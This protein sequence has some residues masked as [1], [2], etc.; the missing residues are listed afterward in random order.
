MTR[1]LLVAAAV[2][3]SSAA[4]AHP[5][6][7]SAPAADATGR[8]HVHFGTPKPPAAAPKAL[9][10]GDTSSAK[11]PLATPKKRK[12]RQELSHPH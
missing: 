8:Q 4:Y 7:G 12:A 10:A 2:A 11:G 9:P 1:I 3:L 5:G 6:H